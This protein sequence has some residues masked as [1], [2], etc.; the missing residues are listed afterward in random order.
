M[1]I[2]HADVRTMAAHTY[3][4]GFIQ[5]AGGK[6]IAVGA[7]ADAPE[8]TDVLDAKGAIAMPGLIDAH[9]H[10]GIWE[11][12][13]GFEG[14]DGNEDTDP[15]TPQLRGIDGVNPFDRSFTEALDYGVTTVV[16]GP[17]SA[18]PIAGQMCALK[19][20]GRRVDSMILREP[21][22]IKMAMGENPKTSYHAKAQSPVTRMA[23]A[24]IIRDQLAK[25]KKYAQQL[26]DAAEDEELDE[27]E[28]DAKCEALLPLL[29]HR[30]KA[31]IHAHRADDIFTAI[32]IAKEY[33]FEYVIVH[34]TEGHLIAQELAEEGA[35]V[36]AGPLIGARTKPELANS[37]IAGVGILN[38]A[39]VEVAI[40]TDHPEVPCYYLLMS[41]QLAMNEGLDA[42]AALRS[43]TINAAK[44][45]G[46]DDRVGSLEVGKD[47]DIVL[48]AQ[49]PMQTHAKPATVI[50]NGKR[51]R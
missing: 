14:D 15:S 18:N 22:A 37:N 44:I 38:K 32:R 11:D 24:S 39:G 4:D 10:I 3:K 50:I 43:I 9:C 13:M 48:F 23:I 41:A 34:G 20:D 17:G 51:V 31:H 1:L 5:C 26:A 7:M 27:P 2:M 6:I 45:C 49:E 8:D 12:G 40:S 28:Y 25:A 47:A 19:T 42:D 29:D 21:L 36:L 46:I 30:I 16:T 35:S 33:D